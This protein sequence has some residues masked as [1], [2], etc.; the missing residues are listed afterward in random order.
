[1]E[2]MSEFPATIKLITGEEVFAIVT[3]HTENNKRLLLVYEPVIIQ[4][5]KL[6]NGNYGF[7][8][9]PWLKSCDDNTF[10]IS[11]DKVITLSECRNKE[12]INYHLRFIQQKN[13]LDLSDPYEERLSKEQGYVSN[14]N[15]MRN[16]LEELFNQ[17]R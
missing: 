15:I 16:K 11:E 4:Q 1:M 2:R 5:V 8:I 13:T 10:L 3:P 17:S 12:L 9:E 6:L 14:V 7:K